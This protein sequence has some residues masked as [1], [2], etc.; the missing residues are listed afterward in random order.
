MLLFL[1]A[2][3]ADGNGVRGAWFYGCIIWL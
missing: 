3:W 1:Y 2:S